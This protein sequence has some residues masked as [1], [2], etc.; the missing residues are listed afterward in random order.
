VI[1][2]EYFYNSVSLVD[3]KIYAVKNEPHRISAHQ[4]M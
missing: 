2:S 4:F 3:V 1:K